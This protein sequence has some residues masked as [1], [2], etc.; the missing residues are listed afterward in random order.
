MGVV[1]AASDG[2]G[3]D[4]SRNTKWDFLRFPRTVV[5]R[6]A[7]VFI[8]IATKPVAR[9]VILFIVYFSCISTKI[10]N[11]SLCITFKLVHQFFE[12]DLEPAHETS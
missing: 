6:V 8:A 9:L 3:L 2:A 4:E 5:E 10:G 7:V 11:N 12:N 1:V